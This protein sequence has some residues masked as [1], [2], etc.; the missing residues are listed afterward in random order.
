MMSLGLVF[1]VLLGQEKSPLD[2]REYRAFLGEIRSRLLAGDLPAAREVARALAGRRVAFPGRE[3]STD[4][5]ILGDVDKAEG[6]SQAREL[7]PRLDSLIQGLGDLDPSASP[8]GAPDPVLLD[9]LRQE[10]REREAQRGGE[11][12]ERPGGVDVPPSILDR[13]QAA[14]DWIT[15][16]GARVFRWLIR[17]LFSQRA[18]NQAASDRTPLFVALLVLLVIGGLAAIALLAWRKKGGAPG[19]SEALSEASPMSPRDEDPLS[20]T[21]TEWERLAGELAQAGRFREA[22]RA[23]YHAVLVTLFRSGI[24]HYRR[25]RTNWEYAHSLSPELA[26]RAGFLEATRGFERIWYGRRDAPAEMAQAYAREARSIL[27]RVRGGGA[28]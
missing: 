3:F 13:L 10:Q 7:L 20:R 9:R 12:S 27:D 28:R 2:L 22:M 21:A 26:W 6:T 5:G 17:L 1:F 8:E 18:S 23:W 24:L 4:R 25:D 11:L 15:D 16:L 14:W 19:S